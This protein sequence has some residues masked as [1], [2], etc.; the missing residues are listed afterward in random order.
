MSIK[1]KLLAESK[2]LDVTVELGSLFE[3]VELSED[4]KEKFSTV[5][6]TVVKS[7]VA[8][9]AESHIAEIA[10]RADVLA[11]EKAEEKIQDI[12]EKVEQ[13][14][15]HITEQW[16]TEN[17]IALE[18]GIKADLF[19]SLVESLKET[20]V[21]HNIVVPEESV[22]VVAEMEQEL[23]ESR[24]ELNRMLAKQTELQESIKQMKRESVLKEATAGLTDVQRDKV[25]ELAENLSFGEKFASQVQHLVEMTA[26]KTPIEQKPIVEGLDEPI[27]EQEEEERPQETPI[28][29]NKLDID[30][31]VEQFMSYIRR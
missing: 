7:K 28:V 18:R 2:A 23:T 17:K 19:E 31:E 11:E 10:E 29:E 12:Q 15:D 22:D 9:L 16:L 1:Q 30:P 5:F 25:M 14:F 21:E 6:E 8:E 26:D 13:Y 24:D 4:V 27:V 20:F 3:S